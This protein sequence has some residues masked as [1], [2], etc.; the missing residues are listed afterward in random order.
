MKGK[1]QSCGE[2][3]QKQPWRQPWQAKSIPIPEKSEQGCFTGFEF[4]LVTASAERKQ[5]TVSGEHWKVTLKSLKMPSPHLLGP[6]E[7]QMAPCRNSGEECQDPFYTEGLK[8][9]LPRHGPR[10]S[11]REGPW[12]LLSSWDAGVRSSSPGLAVP[13]DVSYPKEGTKSCNPGGLGRG[14]C[15]RSVL[16]PK[17][18]LTYAAI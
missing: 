7:W 3:T 16:I 12:A 4:S 6:P 17:T 14:P 5:W 11:G 2:K 15:S 1:V 9:K 18:T 8:G 13:G 10:S